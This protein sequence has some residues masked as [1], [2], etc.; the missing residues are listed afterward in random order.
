MANRFSK[1]NRFRQASASG[2]K[3]S[4]RR[5]GI[6]KRLRYQAENSQTG[7]DLGENAW[8]TYSSSIIR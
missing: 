8:K 1:A 3:S 7:T 2:N 6:G 5:A 4:G